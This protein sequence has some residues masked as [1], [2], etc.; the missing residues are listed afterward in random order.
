MSKIK[1]KIYRGKTFKFQIF[2]SSNFTD[3]KNLLFNFSASCKIQS[4][5]T[6]FIFTLILKFHCF[7]TDDFTVCTMNTV[8]I[9]QLNVFFYPYI[10]I[11]QI[12]ISG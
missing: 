11:K 9:F 10:S 12:I 7:G 5:F 6:F 1:T 2:F 3:L 4:A 8:L